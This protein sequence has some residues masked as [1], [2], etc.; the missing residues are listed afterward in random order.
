MRREIIKTAATSEEVKM[1]GF[2]DEPVKW[3]SQQMHTY[4]LVYLLAH[5]DDGVIWGRFD[6]EKLITSHDVAPQYSPPLREA[7]LQTARI[8]APAGELLIWRDEASAWRGR[9]IAE[10]KPDA[11]AEW[12]EA[13]D[14]SQVLWGTKAEPLERGFTLMSDGSQ[15]LFHVVPFILRGQFDEQTRPLRL[16][17]RH[18]LQADNYGLVRVSASRLVTLGTEMKENNV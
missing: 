1:D 11:T 18:Y 3:L 10:D 15:G 2:V 4:A 14:K 7:T 5:A 6:G 16:V 9:L 8:F 13:F 17:V 12:T